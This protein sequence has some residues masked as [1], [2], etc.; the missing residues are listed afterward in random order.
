MYLILIFAVLCSGAAIIALL[1]NRK[2]EETLSLWIFIIIF[3]LYFY[4]IRGSLIDGVSIVLIASKI[5]FVLCLCYMFIN[6]KRVIKN[7][8]TPGFVMFILFFVLAWW[9][10]RGRMLTSWDEFSH[11]GTVV[12]NMDIFDAFANLPASTTICKGYPPATALLQYFWI[13]VSGGYAEGHLYRAM[14]ILYFSLMLPIFTNVRFRDYGKIVVRTMLLLILPLAFYQD[15]YTNILV[16][17]MLG[18][19]FAGILINYYE[20]KLGAFKFIYISLALF[21]LTITKSSGFGLSIIAI[22]IMAVDI[23]TVQ[24]KNLIIYIKSG[25]IWRNILKIV[26]ILC[27]IIFTLMSK[28]SWSRYLKITK[29][30]ASWNTST[31]GIENIKNLFTDNAPQYQITTIKNFL[32]FLSKQIITNFTIKI[33]YIGWITLL[34]VISIILIKFICKKAEKGRYKLAT[35]TIFS[36]AFIYSLS[37]LILYVFTFS[38]N[39]ATNLASYS[40]YMSTYLLGALTFFVVIICLKEQ[41]GPT[42]FKISWSMI[43]LLFLLLIIKTTPLKDITVLAPFNSKNTVIKRKQYL[44][45]TRIERP[46]FRKTDKMYIISVGSNGFDYWVNRYNVT[47]IRTNAPATFSIGKPYYEGD[48][49]TNDISVEEWVEKLR[50]QYTLVYIVKTNDTFNKTYGE[51]FEGGSKAIKDETLYYVQKKHGKVRLLMRK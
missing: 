7:I 48:I 9:A 43:I 46:L 20:N 31:I 29:T 51:V 8:L 45:I 2:F 39:E 30:D 5:S 23:L 12:R 26:I 15:F 35:I 40:R 17:A 44:P 4:G 28:L 42:R 6:I 19:M 18:V 37:L 1:F 11:W 36:G 41:A 32:T 50:N 16:D 14:N 49:W 38:V 3:I 10:Q 21:T 34:L 33:S 24:R 47:P 22:I 25:K 27:P 13:K